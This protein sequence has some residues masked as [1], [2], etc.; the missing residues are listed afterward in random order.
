MVIL[1]II[2][3]ILCPARDK[4]TEL[5]H[6]VQDE[7]K[8]EFTFQYQFVGIVRRN[9]VRQD[10]R[11]NIRFDF[12]VNTMLN[13]PA[14]ERTDAPAHSE[15]LQLRNECMRGIRQHRY[16]PSRQHTQ[17]SAICCPNRSAAKQSGRPDRASKE[18]PVCR[19]CLYTAG[20]GRTILCRKRSSAKAC[21]VRHFTGCGEVK[22]WD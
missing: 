20:T 19:Q 18:R 17:G 9:M 21:C 4:L 14:S 1:C 22:P 2:L 10:P 13:N 12:D 6:R 3:G 8:N 5:I 15:I 16:P 11:S 7:L